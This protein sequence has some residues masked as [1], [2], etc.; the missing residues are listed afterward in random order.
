MFYYRYRPISELS[1]K[2]LRYNELYFAS[3]Q[4]NNDPY[5]GQIL[6]KY[7]FDETTWTKIFNIAWQN[8]KLD[9]ILLNKIAINLASKMHNV[10]TYE[11]VIGVNFLEEIMVNFSVGEIIAEVLDEQIR[12]FIDIYRPSPKYTVSFSKVDNNMLMWSHYASKHKGYCLIFK[13]IDNALYQDKKQ[14]RESITVKTPKGIIARSAGCS[15]PKQFQFIDVDYD[16]DNK[17]SSA[18]DFMPPAIS[19]FKPKDDE[20]RVAIANKIHD[21]YFIKHECWK[22]EEESRLVLDIQYPWMF[23]EHIDYSAEQRLFHYD[24]AQLVGIICGARMEEK[25]KDKK[26]RYKKFSER[27]IQRIYL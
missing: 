21:K 15:I 2:E 22:Y 1:L 14:I 17:I 13:P 20:E 5:D 18:S 6:L 19:K 12:R 24:V 16:S 26:M 4:E 25:I 3:T 27:G 23:G 10:K 7:D 8:V 11:E 9:K